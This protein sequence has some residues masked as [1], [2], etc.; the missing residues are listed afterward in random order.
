MRTKILYE[1][2]EIIV[3][4]KPAG[5]A[6]QTAHIGQQDMVSELKNYLAAGQAPYL[7][8][9][10]RL[11]QPVEGALVFAKT[12]KAAAALTKQLQAGDFCKEYLAAV[13]GKPAENCGTLVD[14][15]TKE[16]NLARVVTKTAKEKEGKRAI[17][18]YTLLSTALHEEKEISLLRVQIEHGR[19]HQIRAQLSHAGMP[20]LGDSKYGSEERFANIALCASKLSFKHPVT[21]KILEYTVSAEN[22]VFALFGA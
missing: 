12:Q 3:A 17:L 14:F 11:D 22:P 8:I 4:H 21:G 10:H 9:I 16:K 2:K 20:I 13:G 1:D 6:V 5:L 18:Y 15:L 19:F 7:G